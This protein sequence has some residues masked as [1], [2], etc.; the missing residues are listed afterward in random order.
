MRQLLSRMVD[1]ETEIEVVDFKDRRNPNIYDDL[2][3]SYKQ[4][5]GREVKDHKEGA[6]KY[7]SQLVNG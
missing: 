6:S 1:I 3:R 5:F 4:F 2:I 7:I